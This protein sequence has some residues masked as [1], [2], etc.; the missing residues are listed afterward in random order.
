MTKSF[1]STDVGFIFYFRG[2]TASAER[3]FY[4]RNN[5]QMRNPDNASD[6]ESNGGCEIKL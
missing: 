4:V 2:S 3:T 6:N 1:K 5:G